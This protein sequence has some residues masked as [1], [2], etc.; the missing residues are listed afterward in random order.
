MNVNQQFLKQSDGGLLTYLGL[1]ASKPNSGLR[2]IGDGL[3][4]SRV[5][6]VNELGI[7]CSRGAVVQ[8]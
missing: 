7:I 4:V 5:E 2:T 8:S 1:H 3:L 6:D